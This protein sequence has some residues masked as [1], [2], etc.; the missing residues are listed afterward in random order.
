MLA[1]RCGFPRRG[2]ACT[3]SYSPSGA[4][5]CSRVPNAFSSINP[6]IFE[7]VIS[8]TVE[9][10]ALALSALTG[11]H[12]HDPLSFP[13]P[14]EDLL[15]ALRGLCGIAGSRIARTSAVFRSSPR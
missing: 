11:P 5:R 1:A 15:V 6:F 4:P 10:A 14:D 3:A 7:G 13:F 9:D 12:P 2:V 8:R